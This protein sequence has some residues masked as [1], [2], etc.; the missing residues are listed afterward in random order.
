MLGTLLEYLKEIDY[1]ITPIQIYRGNLE[2]L[3][4]HGLLVVTF[5]WD[6][7]GRCYNAAQTLSEEYSIPSI[8]LE[9]GLKQFVE[10]EDQSCC[11]STVQYK[12]SEAPR[13]TVAAV[14]LTKEEVSQHVNLVNGFRACRYTSSAQAINSISTMDF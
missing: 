7:S 13:N 10:N 11:L 12:I 3:Y 2:K 8:R 9:G 6:G 1:A 4:G 5:C 14:I